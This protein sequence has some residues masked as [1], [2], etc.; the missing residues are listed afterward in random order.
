MSASLPHLVNVRQ[1]RNS[2]SKVELTTRLPINVC[3]Q[4]NLIG[5]VP[6]KE[7]PDQSRDEESSRN[8]GSSGSKY[9]PAIDLLHWLN[10]SEFRPRIGVLK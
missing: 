6:N 8:G 5:S 2:S 9:M 10:V 1:P 7:L 4:H 3:E